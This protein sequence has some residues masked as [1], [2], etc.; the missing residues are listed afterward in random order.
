MAVVFQVEVLV[1]KI[2]E[3]SALG[4]ELHLREFEGV[5]AELGVDLLEMVLVDVDVAEGM[6]ELAGTITQDLGY[7]HG[8]QGIA[9]DI[10]RHP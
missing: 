10:K 4:V 8:K 9:G 5:A 2:L 3:A 6:D 7:H 1:D